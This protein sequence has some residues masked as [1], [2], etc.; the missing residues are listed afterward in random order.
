MV[1][2]RPSTEGTMWQI[3]YGRFA[4]F[5]CQVLVRNERHHVFVMSM[6]KR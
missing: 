4:P 1:T 5:I 6:T 2:I 3:T